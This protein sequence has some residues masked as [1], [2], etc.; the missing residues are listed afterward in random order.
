[1]EPIEIRRRPAVPSMTRGGV[2]GS[3]TARRVDRYLT[4]MSGPPVAVGDAAE[5]V[6]LMGHLTSARTTNPAPARTR[7]L[8]LL[9]PLRRLRR[10]LLRGVG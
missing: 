6:E 10:F 9:A 2:P 1:M 5:A 8:T 4:V 3:A 7:G